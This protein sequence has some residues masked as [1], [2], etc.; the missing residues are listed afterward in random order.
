MSSLVR[1]T[2]MRRAEARLVVLVGDLEAAL[3]LLLVRV[4]AQ[5]VVIEAQ[6]HGLRLRRP[7]PQRDRG[8][9]GLRAADVELRRMALPEVADAEGDAARRA[10][11]VPEAARARPCAAVQPGVA[12][13]GALADGEAVRVRLQQRP[14]AE[15]GDVLQQVR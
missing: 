9:V 6:V 7:E 14:V 8:R 11:D 10:A 3:E 4:L 13:R 2:P 15:G 1:A 12:L 5:A